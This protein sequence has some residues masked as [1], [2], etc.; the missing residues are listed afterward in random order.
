MEKVIYNKI[1][2]D[3][4]L[5]IIT[6]LD[7]DISVRKCLSDIL[8]CTKNR[9]ERKVILDLAL[10]VGINEYRFVSCKVTDT[11]KVIWDSSTYIAPSGN[12]VKLANSFVLQKHEIL[13]NSMLP[14]AT[15]EELYIHR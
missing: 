5:G 15:K 6:I 14:N 12:I 3:N 10:K 1:T 4:Y 9:G 13:A 2:D 8:I 11:G 7:Y